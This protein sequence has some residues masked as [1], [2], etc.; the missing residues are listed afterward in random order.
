VTAF[1]FDRPISVFIDLGFPR[2]VESVLDAY[3]LLL[4][5]KGIP[6]VDYHAAVDV[7]RKA[8]NGERTVKQAHDAFKRFAANR[9]ILSEEALD[10]AANNFAQQWERLRT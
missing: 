6:E 2:E 7:C 4:E 9:G 5:W 1:K 8:L 10:R 3:D